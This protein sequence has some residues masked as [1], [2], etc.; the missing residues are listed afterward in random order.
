VFFLV[1]VKFFGLIR[2]QYN[3]T[4]LEVTSGTIHEIM[5]FILKSFPHMKNEDLHEAVL[6]INNEKVM[7]LNRFSRQVHDGDEVVF[8]NFVGGG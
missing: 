8:T 1:I 2:S 4:Q 3:V 5:D 7:N 6:F